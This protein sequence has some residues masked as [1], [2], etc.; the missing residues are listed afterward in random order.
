MPEKYYPRVCDTYIRLII[1]V[2]DKLYNHKSLGKIFT[3]RKLNWEGSSRI[4]DEPWDAT[5]RLVKNQHY[6]CE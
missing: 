5:Y 1:K 6:E 3:S 2:P 4:N